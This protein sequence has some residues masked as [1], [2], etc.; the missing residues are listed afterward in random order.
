MGRDEE[1]VI[2]EA[3][4]FHSEEFNMLWELDDYGGAD[5]H[6]RIEKLLRSIRDGI[7]SSRGESVRGS[8]RQNGTEVR[9]KE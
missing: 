8:H 1:F 2:T 3:I 7:K 4:K 9:E 5:M 6:Y